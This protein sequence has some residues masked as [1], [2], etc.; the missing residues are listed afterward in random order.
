MVSLKRKD[1]ITN[2]MFAKNSVQSQFPRFAVN[3]VSARWHKGPDQVSFTP[4]PSETY[5]KNIDTN[6]YQ[7]V[8]DLPLAQSDTDFIPI[9]PYA[10]SLFH[11]LHLARFAPYASL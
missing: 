8:N 7:E 9:F 1:S 3:A 5:L 10:P 4:S 2:V 6:I 11:N